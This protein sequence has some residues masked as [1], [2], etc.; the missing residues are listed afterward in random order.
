MGVA[1]MFECLL[2]TPLGKKAGTLRVVPSADGEHFSGEL[3]N[4]LVGS[5]AISN[6]AID[7]DMLLCTLKIDKPMR[8]SA[9]CEVIVDGDKIVG[10]VTAGMFGK[11]K[12][13]GQRMA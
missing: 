5:V 10:S 11:M 1:G 2:D 12:L 13:S 8:M 4:D 9:E 7:G 6:G 3:S